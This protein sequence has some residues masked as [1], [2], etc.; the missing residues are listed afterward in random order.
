M[1]GIRVPLNVQI[2][3]TDKC[4]LFCP[5]C[6]HF[7]NSD[8]RKKPSLDLSDD[9]VMNIAGKLVAAN[10]M[11]VILT[12]GE[13]MLRKN[14]MVALVSRFKQSNMYVSINTNLIAMTDYLLSELLGARMDG[15]LVSCPSSDPSGYSKAT[16]GGKYQKFEENLRILIA[17]GAH[18]SINMVVNSSNL[19][20]IRTTAYRMATLGVKNFRGDSCGA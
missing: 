1:L 4:N 15:F 2:E 7:D 9:S 18:F 10:V 19:D 13:P 8:G 12:G 11:G 20:Q 17:S 16:G 6:Y 14:L 3:I 5:H